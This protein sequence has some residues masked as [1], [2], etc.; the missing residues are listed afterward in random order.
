MESERKKIFDVKKLE[1]D[2][3]GR[4]Q[5]GSA[6]ASIT[7]YSKNK[8]QNLRELP[9]V[10]LFRHVIDVSRPPRHLFPCAERIAVHSALARRVEDIGVTEPERVGFG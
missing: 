7:V 4:G 9:I 6:D 1:K 10:I 3:G 2:D 5:R 8:R